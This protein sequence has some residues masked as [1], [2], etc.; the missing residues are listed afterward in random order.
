MKDSICPNPACKG[1]TFEIQIKKVPYGTTRTEVNV[2]F[3]Q[4]S[5]CGTIIGV[6]QTGT[7][8]SRLENCAHHITN[9]FLESNVDKH[10]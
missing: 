3:V 4:C 5:Q 9:K 8:I 6:L 7:V 1:K 2:E 10:L